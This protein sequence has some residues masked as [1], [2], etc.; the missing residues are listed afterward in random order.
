M[1]CGLG[2]VILIF[3]II[4]H[5]L[6]YGVVES[7]TL[8][9]E[10]ETLEREVELL[11]QVVSETSERN[12]EQQKL[13]DDLDSRRQSA[14]IAL[15][16]IDQR[17]TEQSQE[18][19]EL[20][21]SLEEQATLKAAE[22]VAD[23]T[24]GEEEYLL[25]LRVEGDRIAILIDH[26]GSMTH[27]KLVDVF[28][29]KVGSSAERQRGPKWQRAKRATRWLLNRVPEQSSVVVVGFSESAD[30]LGTGAWGRLSDADNLERTL[31]DL[32]SLVPDGAT[33][34]QAAF[35]A[36]DRLGPAPTDVYLITDGL[37]TKV[38]GRTR[39]CARG[40]TISPRC[41]LELFSDM[42]RS[43]R[44]QLARLHLNVVMLPL[45]GD[46]EAANAYWNVA[47]ATGGLLISP[48]QSWP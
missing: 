30:V 37:P 13:G 25:G 28:Q 1:A 9:T 12:A 15:A 20:N 19:A 47:V 33:N 39:R 4:K 32:E 26:S 10:L 46:W 24:T 11:R 8:A 2:A 14:E 23:T 17:L 45:E 40:E 5:N 38:T 42:T 48:P 7:D 44:T 6:D 36:I 22:I 29:A 27:E 35:E 41:R 21:E 34:L 16:A 43:A 18:N 31:T 3:L